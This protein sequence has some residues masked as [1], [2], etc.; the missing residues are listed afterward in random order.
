MKGGD[1]LLSR[2]QT[3]AKLRSGKDKRKRQRQRQQRERRVG[4]V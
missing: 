2:R 1:Q 3:L 4:S